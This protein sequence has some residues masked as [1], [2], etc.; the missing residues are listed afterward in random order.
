MPALAQTLLAGR[1]CNAKRSLAYQV[2]HTATKMHWIILKCTKI[3]QQIYYN[4]FENISKYCRIYK[5][6]KIYKINTKRVE[7]EPGAARSW[8]GPSA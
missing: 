6:H 4:I 3:V 5:I 1:Y 7:P 2:Y 8:A